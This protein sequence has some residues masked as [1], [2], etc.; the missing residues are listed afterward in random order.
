MLS[1]SEH[2]QSVLNTKDLRKNNRVVKNVLR[3]ILGL[4][5]LIKSKNPSIFPST[6]DDR[7]STDSFDKQVTEQVPLSNPQ[8]VNLRQE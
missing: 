7:T 6:N 8:D 1:I 4:E 3:A 5:P 2:I